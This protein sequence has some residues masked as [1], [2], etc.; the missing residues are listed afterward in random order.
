LSYEAAF[1]LANDGCGKRREALPS[2][3][4]D[5]LRGLVLIHEM[6][7][8]MKFAVLGALTCIAMAPIA[9]A[10]TGGYP[11]SPSHAIVGTNPDGTPRYGSDPGR[12]SENPGT[13]VGRGGSKASDSVTEQGKD[14]A[15]D[16]A[17]Q[18]RP[19]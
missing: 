4:F 12:S 2:W 18:V 8:D 19:H 1:S 9:S 16:R 5:R 15:K 11:A 10:E 14:T 13:T 3:R 17:G 6:E 7:V